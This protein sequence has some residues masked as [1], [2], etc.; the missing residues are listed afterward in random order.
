M[1]Q[2]GSCKR[3]EKAEEHENEDDTNCGWCPWNIPQRSVKETGGLEIRRK[4]QKKRY[5]L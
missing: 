4:L 1:T 2:P 3:R 5:K